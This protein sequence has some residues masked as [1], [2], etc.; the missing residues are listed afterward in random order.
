MQKVDVRDVAISVHCTMLIASRLARNPIVLFF[1]FDSDRTDIL[2]RL[3]HP[4]DLRY[5]RHRSME[6][7]P[8]YTVQ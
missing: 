4:L 5:L 8:L 7:M 3:S 1:I 2:L 6:L